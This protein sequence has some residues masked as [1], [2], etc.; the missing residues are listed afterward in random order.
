M[1]CHCA[2]CIF[3]VHLGNQ[4]GMI[5]SQCTAAAGRNDARRTIDSDTTFVRH[6]EHM[7]GA[8]RHCKATV[9]AS[10]LLSGSSNR[11]PPAIMGCPSTNTKLCNPPTQHMAV[12]I[13]CHIP[14]VCPSPPQL[15]VDCSI[16]GMYSDNSTHH[17]LHSLAE[18]Q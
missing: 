18:Q 9:P 5:R 17:T 15:A 3:D 13:S 14:I 2:V 12:C 11:L 10:M 1:L 7:H 8:A 6:A 4:P 16:P